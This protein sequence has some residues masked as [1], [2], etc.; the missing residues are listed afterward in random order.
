MS[1]DIHSKSN[2]NV[3]LRKLEIFNESKNSIPTINQSFKLTF[4]LSLPC[5]DEDKWYFPGDN[6]IE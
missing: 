3:S 4:F 6:P 1:K 2:Y 5:N